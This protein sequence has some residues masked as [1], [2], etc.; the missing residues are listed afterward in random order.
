MW[1]A[2]SASSS[3]PASQPPDCHHYRSLVFVGRTIPIHELLGRRAVTTNWLPPTFLLL[4]TPPLL[5]GSLVGWLPLLWNFIVS[6]STTTTLRPH[7]TDDDDNDNLLFCLLTK[8]DQTQ[9]NYS[10]YCYGVLCPLEASSSQ[11]SC[12][13][14]AFIVHIPSS[15]LLQ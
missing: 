12:N 1:T 5:L 4:M 15:L 10:E 9:T 11:P 6:Q 8:N 2:I 13:G 14:W 7:C 3:Q